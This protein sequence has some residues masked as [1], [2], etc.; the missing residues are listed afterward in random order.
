MGHHREETRHKLPE[1]SP[2]RAT[3]DALQSLSNTLHHDNAARVTLWKQHLGLLVGLVTELC[4]AQTKALKEGKQ[5]FGINHVVY[6]NSSDRLSHSHQ[7]MVGT[8]L[9]SKFAED[10][11]QPTL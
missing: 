2:G 4:L 11:P 3:R 1:S 5:P 10:N 6:M 8:L 9:K 7:G